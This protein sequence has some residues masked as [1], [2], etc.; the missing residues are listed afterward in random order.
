[1][2]YR[3]TFRTFLFVTTILACAVS[4]VP[5]CTAPSFD[6]GI[7]VTAGGPGPT[8][9]IASADLNGDGITDILVPRYGTN[10]VSLIFGSATGTPT[11][12]LLTSVQRPNAVAVADFNHDGK[13]DLAVSHET[14]PSTGTFVAVILGDGAGGFGAPTDYP[15][16]LSQPLVTADFN[17]DGNVDVF[18]GN[19][20]TNNSQILLGTGSGGLA[21]PFT[22]NTSNN[23]HAVAVDL[24]ND[25]KLDLAS[26]LDGGS[27]LAVVLGDGTGHFGGTSF[28]PISRTLFGNIAAGDFNNDGKPD[29]VTSGQSDG[30]SLLLGDGAGGFAPTTNVSTGFSTKGV[31]VGDFNG[32]GKLDLTTTGSNFIALLIGN[33]NGGFVSTTSYITNQSPT[34]L[35]TGDF[36]GDTRLDV[37]AVNCNS[38][39]SAA[40]IM[41]GDGHGSLRSVKVLNLGQSPLAIASGDLNADGKL[42]LAVVN[43]SQ[44][45]VSILIGDG[46]GN[47]G[48]P[49][50]FAVGNQP[51]SVTLGDLNGDQKLDLVT[52]NYVG[53]T[54]T[55][56]FGDGLGGF[57]PPGN[58]LVVPGF[59]PD[60]AAIGDFNND[61]KPD[62]A[63]AYAS[64]SYVSIFLGNGDGGF[65]S[66]TNFTV[67]TNALHI[68]V[69][70]LNS[71][72]KADLAVATISGVSILLGNGTGG[73][74]AATTLPTSS[75]VYDV[76]AED[77]NRDGKADIA[78]MLGNTTTALIYT[79]DGLGGFGS[80]VSFTT[81]SGPVSA[82]I[83]D[84]NGD[85]DP[86]LAT[87]NVSGS[88]S[89]LLGDGAGGF[90]AA[91][92]YPA[93]GNTTRSIASGDF[94]S[95]GRPDLALANQSGS[96]SLVFNSCTATRLSVP[97]ISISDASVSEGDT[98]TTTATFTVNLSAP[99]DR[100]VS[101][102]FYSA[103]SDAQ[104]DVDYQTVQGRL[105]FAPGTTTQTIAVPVA[106]DSLDEFDE[107]FS[108]VLAYPLNTTISKQRGEATILDNDSP[109]SVSI[110]DV[111][112]P[113]GN[114]GTSP[115]VFTV[116]LSNVSGKPIL[117][118]YTTADGSATAGSD[119]ASTTG[120]VSIAA[121]VLSTTIP[122]LVNG[123]TFSESNET[124]V[125]NLIGAGNA[126]L[127]KAAGTGTILNDDGGVQFASASFSV[128]EGAGVANAIVTRTGDLSGIATVD[129]ATADSAGT[130]NCNVISGNAS[131]RCDYETTV[132]TLHFAAGESSKTISIPIIGDAYAEGN[133]N[134]IITLSNSFGVAVLTPSAATITINDDETVNGVNPID[135]ADFFVRQHYIDFLNREA[136]A[137]GLAFWSNQI[138]EC[139]QPGASCNAVVRRINVSAAFFLSIEFQE[140]GYLVEK[141]Y[142]TA[143][144]DALG[145]SNSGA[146]HQLPVPIVRLNEFL[147][148]TQEIGRGVVVGQTGWEQVLEN[149]K[150][151]F[152]LRFV[153]RSRFASAF[154]ISLTPAQFVDQLFARAGM[155]PSVSERASIINEFGRA[156]TSADNA[157]RGR[158]LRRVA[159]NS[160]LNQA[161]KNKAFVL[162]Q[163]FGYLRRN[164]NDPQDTDYT[165]YDFWLTK[166]NEFNG[167]FIRAEMVKAFLDSTEYRARFGP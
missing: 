94:N 138:T 61:S 73:F 11:V 154:P 147:P 109:P 163:F 101:V 156:G 155:T 86:D 14:S 20:S 35:V 151:A 113:E 84:F 74:G 112:L 85:R 140:T 4:A 81:G 92:T 159:E 160:T 58:S 122:I 55:I 166:L 108:V 45:N 89:V 136:D 99:A 7:V 77:F 46:V 141:L 134:F 143:Y 90:G 142:K 103:A 71:D 124:F 25:G 104:K 117:L 62:L 34:N 63:V 64:A 123:D 82:T 153:Q 47:F 118:Q 44:N 127:L 167:D 164:P 157:A 54:A 5:Q 30:I 16:S 158:A 125:V 48:P 28:F 105:T 67:P 83:A 8:G 22:V 132:G 18:I 121:G 162:M 130:N 128:A 102:S 131:A 80:P 129:Y 13:P 115:A 66:A 10:T 152:I 145:T 39:T 19:S 33:G 51:R 41:F 69:H 161:E 56:L 50:N 49:T 87:G 6:A 114:A 139:Q 21:A 23:T 88:A 59:N 9:E 53:G 78:V 15:T 52:T 98:G 68:A 135:Q 126:T 165:G 146:T 96:V 3:V 26:E 29:L 31:A 60:Y 148:D 43:I 38:C 93:G 119:Y 120:T 40:T 37:S 149:N 2:L 17:N 111:S 24:N 32:D 110:D 95:D 144:G 42:D 106:G 137:S 76:I 97:T 79:G 72:G 133:E 91:A 116:T 75:T 150:V 12:V 36:N 100:T 70:D 57:T 65:G 27:S 107:H 1:M